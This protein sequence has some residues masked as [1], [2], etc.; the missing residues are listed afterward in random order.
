[1]T[2]D[3]DLGLIHAGLSR[4]RLTMDRGR[5]IGTGLA[6]LAAGGLLALAG[7]GQGPAHPPQIN[8]AGQ[9]YCDPVSQFVTAAD[10]TVL[11]TQAAAERTG[12]AA[13]NA[14]NP[15]KRGDKATVT[16]AVADIAPPPPPNPAPEDLH[17]TLALHQVHKLALHHHHAVVARGD[18]ASVDET[19]PASGAA[20]S[21]AAASAVSEPQPVAQT[22]AQLVGVMPGHTE[23]F[24]PV[25]GEH[26]AAD[27]DGDLGFD[28][29]ARTPRRQL[30]HLGAPYP[31]TQWAWDITAVHGG[32]HKLTITTVVEGVDSRGS[33]YQLISTPRA[34]SFT[35]IVTPMEQIL[36]AI[37]TAPTWL[38]AVT[39]LVAAITALVTGLVAFR[40]AIGNLF[41]RKP[42][43]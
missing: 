43:K 26:M 7:C 14:P 25:I 41:G 8:T 42:P 35:V 32:P 19:T 12:T 31:A 16:L 28:I 40:K 20:P 17:T 4:G 18:P 30:V 5:K 34:Y 1:L 27:L 24:T 36:D 11:Q 3:S 21:S 29:K 39:T 2:Y 37:E 38:K 22:P 9:V 23:Q 6:L 10:C 13:F 33:H 15:M